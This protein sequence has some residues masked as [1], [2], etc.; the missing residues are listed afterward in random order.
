MGK[1]GTLRFLS[2]ATLV[3]VYLV[4]LAGSVV[5]MTGSGMGCPDWPKCFGEWIPPTDISQLPEDYESYFL[6]KRKAKLTKY[7]NLVEGLGM[8]DIAEAMRNDPLLLESE[9]F[10]ARGT[11]I[12]YI[13]R[14]FGF[15]SGNLLLLLFIASLW[16][17][18]KKPIIPL[19]VFIALVAISFQAWLGSVVVATNLL[20]WTITIHMVVAFLIIG[21]LIWVYHLLPKKELDKVIKGKGWL[22]L[23]IILTLVQ[24]V[25]GTQVRQEI[26]YI[27]MEWSDRWMWI[28]MLSSNFEIHRS[29]S[30]L[31]VLVNGYFL[32]LNRSLWTET[33]FRALGILLGV[34]ILLGMTLAYLGMP[35][36]AQPLHLLMATLFFGAQCW[37]LFRPK[38]QIEIA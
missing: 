20:P 21:L 2:I 36:L 23:A 15:I 35:A 17:V 10:D 4:I 9:P 6:G 30:I 5:R 14:L 26:D 38:G 29:F 7:T 34:E 16:W 24:V 22:G 19:M 18:K 31:L 11:W 33:S 3:A 25:L 37:V 32:Y 8:A 13:N 1:T 12:E 28:D 27:A